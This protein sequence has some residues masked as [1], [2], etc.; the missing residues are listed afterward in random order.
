MKVN[1]KCETLSDGSEVWNIVIETDEGNHV[2]L[3]AIDDVWAHDI[4]HK[5]EKFCV[6]ANG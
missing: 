3:G 4:A 2:I 5:I 6:F 1:T